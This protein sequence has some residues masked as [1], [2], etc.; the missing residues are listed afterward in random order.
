MRTRFATKRNGSSYVLTAV[1][2]GKKFWTDGNR[3]VRKPL[4]VFEN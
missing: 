4:F 1:V 2:D 3:Y